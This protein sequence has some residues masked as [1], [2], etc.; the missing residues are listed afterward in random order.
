MLQ[1]Q[2][3]AGMKNRLFQL[4]IALLAVSLAAQAEVTFNKEVLPVLQKHCQEC[5]RP[6]EA[7]PMPLLTYKDA[8]PYAKAIKQAVLSKKMPPWF[9]DSHFGKFANDRTLAQTEIDTLAAWA[10]SGAKEGKEADA[11]AP[12]SYAAGWTIGKPDL[13]IDMSV[14]YTVP[15]KGTVDYTYFIVPA[16]FTEDKWIEKIEVRP[17]ARSVVHHIV[18]FSRAPGSKYLKD[19]PLRAAFVPP[20]KKQAERKP[21]TGAGAFAGLGDDYNEMVSVYVPGGLAYETKPGQARLIKAG[22]DLVFQMHY[23]ANGKETVDRSQVGIVFAKEAPKQRVVNTFIMNPNLHIPPGAPEHR[24]EAKVQLFEDVVLQSLFPHMHL[25]GRAFQYVAKY[26][27]GESETLLKVPNYDFNWQ[28]TYQLEKPILLP[29]G[30]ELTATAWYNN[31][32]QN[33]FNPDP[34]AD[35]YWGDQSW[36]RDAGRLCRLRDSRIDEPRRYR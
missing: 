5:H 33:R 6:G 27:S 1:L 26:P 2:N 4:S 28:L 10:D 20:Q 25:R 16:G 36:G 8:R 7:A 32:P 11:P 14:D 12:K 22:S 18:L 3:G 13:V 30:T 9:A 34:K 15:A 31:S 23:T 35:V 24:V 21:D 17:G 29:K 19:A